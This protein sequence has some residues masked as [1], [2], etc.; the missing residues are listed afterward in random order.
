MV[1]LACSEGEDAVD[2]MSVMMWEREQVLS[3]WTKRRCSGR[4]MVGKARWWKNRRAQE[5]H[6]RHEAD[7][8]HTYLLYEK[9]VMYEYKG[10]HDR[11][12]NLREAV[13]LQE[14]AFPHE[15]AI[16]R[17]IACL[18]RGAND[19]LIDLSAQ[20]PERATMVL[21]LRSR[22]SS[23]TRFIVPQRHNVTIYSSYRT[24]VVIAS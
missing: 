10:Y 21:L 23:S 20:P 14:V 15:A 22:M 11:P 6:G 24:S 4:R 12:R 8:G 19:A 16:L 7:D 17:E 1:R 18:A 3:A 9:D 13:V 5:W 2:P